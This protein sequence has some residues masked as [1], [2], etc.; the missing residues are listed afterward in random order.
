ML[1]A[2]G[3]GVGCLLLGVV[4]AQAQNAS[5][6]ISPQFS[7]ILQAQQHRDAVIAAAQESTSWKRY[8][9]QNAKF[10]PLPMMRIWKSPEFDSAGVPIAGLWGESLE[11]SGC[12]VARKKLNVVTAVSGPGSLT[13]GVLAPGD[14]EAN[15]LLQKD[16]SRHVYAA[17]MTKAPREC[18][19]V[20]LDDTQHIRKEAATDPRIAGPVLVE[21]WTVIACDQTIDV[22][23]KFIPDATGRTI[24]AH[25][26]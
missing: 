25:P 10:T 13:T 11:A 16:T 1:K 20:F 24:G 26:L 9:C 23:V 14:T 22:E 15:P 18:K 21:K 8:N 12:G 4:A 6:Q 2:L 17:A 19:K 5:A 3:F 7:A